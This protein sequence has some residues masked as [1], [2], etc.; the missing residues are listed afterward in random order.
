M[1]ILF[2]L[3]ERRYPARDIASEKLASKCGC[4]DVNVTE[5]KSLERIANSREGCVEN[6]GNT[7][8]RSNF[9]VCENIL[10]QELL[11]D[12][13]TNNCQHSN[14]WNKRRNHPETHS[15]ETCL[16]LWNNVATLGQKG[17]EENEEVEERVEG[18]KVE[19]MLGLVEEE[20]DVKE[21]VASV[22]FFL[23]QLVGEEGWRECVEVTL[24]ITSEFKM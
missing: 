22:H 6:N 12:S 15:E 17:R 14:S 16:L 19:E 13:R 3:F 4:P 1:N 24:A 7:T 10:K 9:D 5:N 21:E 11:E 2:Q 23:E 8:G 20:E 18:D